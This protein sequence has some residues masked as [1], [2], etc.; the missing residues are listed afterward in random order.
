MSLL[1]KLFGASPFGPLLEHAQK[2]HSC[3]KLVIPI[4]E[5]LRKEDYKEVRRLQDQ[6]SKLEFEADEIKHNIRDNLSRRYLLPVSREDLDIYLHQQDSIADAVQDFAVISIIRR[7]RIHPELGENFLA[8]VAHIVS[9]GDTLLGAAEEM[10]NLAE[11]SFKGAEARKVLSLIAGL[12]EQEWKA[13][14]MQRQ[15]SI[16]I[17]EREKELDPITILFY[18]KILGALSEIANFAENTGDVLRRMIVKGR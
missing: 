9:V 10:V 3:V 12:G 6:V 5:A 8:F 18:E 2:V 7:T 15:L 11:T 14:R 17:Y 16:Q 13:D 4:M 1:T